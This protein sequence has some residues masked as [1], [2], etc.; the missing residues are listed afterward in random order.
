MVLAGI[1]T[2]ILPSIASVNLSFCTANLKP[3]AAAK[4]KSFP[5]ILSSTPVSTGRDSSVAAA[6]ATLDIAFFKTPA[7]T[8][9]LIPSS[10][11]GMG[12]N[13]SA[14]IPFIVA[15]DLPLEIFNIP[16]PSGNEKSILSPS[17]VLTNSV[18]I[19][20]GKVMAPSSSIEAPI[21]VVIA[22]S[23]LVADNFSLD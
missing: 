8:T 19:L 22:I 1:I 23:K 5:S 15:L 7:L 2:S 17:R 11:V 3:S 4:L 9:A 10:T 13:S 14:S 16:F 6:K 21:H 12:G 20:A 18:R